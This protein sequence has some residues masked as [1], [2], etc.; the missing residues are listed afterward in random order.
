MSNIRNTM[1][2]KYPK[3]EHLQTFRT[4]EGDILINSN[5]SNNKIIATS[6]LI[7]IFYFLLTMSK[8]FSFT[9]GILGGSPVE[10]V[11]RVLSNKIVTVHTVIFL[12]IVFL[13]IKVINSL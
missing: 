5:W 6:I 11:T 9:S 3:K 8:S 13:I 1:A 4:S 12:L 2:S 10:D 7:A